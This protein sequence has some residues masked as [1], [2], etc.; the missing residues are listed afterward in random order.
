MAKLILD[1]VANL[2]NE[3]S[4]VSTI[5]INSGRIETALENTLSR[6]GTT[7][8]QMN[9]DLDMNSHRI[10]NATGITFQLSLSDFTNI[11]TN[12][13]LG[14]I[15]AGTGAIEQL[16]GTQAT[17]LLN[18]FT[19]TLKGLVPLSGGGSTNFL[20]ADGTWASPPGSAVLNDGD[21]GDITVTS[22]GNVW[23]IDPNTITLAKMV[24]IPT[25][26]LLGRDTTG[27]GTV[28][29][30]A[31]GGCIEFTDTGSLRLSTFSGDVTKSAGSTI[32]TI[33]NDTIIYAKMQNV[34]AT[35]RFIGRITSGS[36]DPEE[37]TGTQA[38]TLLDTFTSTLKGLVPLSG[39]GTSNFLRAD[40]SWSA[41]LTT[42]DGDKGDIT[43]TVGGTVWTIDPGVVTYAKQQN[44]SA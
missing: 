27:T 10:L 14:R 37:L 39:G 34:S 25:D 36:G 29:L 21:K 4:V 15:T 38:T 1:D 16:T 13:I 17:Y 3:A 33:P 30:I 26:T 5:N 40:G 35:S 8:N 2:Q 43:V 9:A 42:T 24:S 19:S 44:I 28:E 41:P 11:S 6:D 18:L 22:G 23:T 7:P 32:L 20:R 12:V 31:V